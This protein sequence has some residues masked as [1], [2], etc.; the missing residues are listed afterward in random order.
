MV[1]VSILLFMMASYTFFASCPDCCSFSSSS[2]L[3]VDVSILLFMMSSY[4]FSFS[5]CDLGLD[6]VGLAFEARFK[7]FRALLED[8]ALGFIS[9]APEFAALREILA[10]ALALALALLL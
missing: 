2:S 7:F 4:S 6:F 8:L 9:L 3:M 5:A 10:L 1:D